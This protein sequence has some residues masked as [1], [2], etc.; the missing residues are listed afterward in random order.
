MEYTRSLLENKVP[1]TL[2]C[3]F[4]TVLYHDATNAP[5]RTVT[6]VTGINHERAYVQGFDGEGKPHVLQETDNPCCREWV[7]TQSGSYRGDATRLAEAGP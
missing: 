4:Y 1:L 7:E 3:N 6:Y 5:S 2:F